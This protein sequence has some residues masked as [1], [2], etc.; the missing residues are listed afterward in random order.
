M[1]EKS[2]ATSWS[3]VR[4]DTK[5]CFGWCLGEEEDSLGRV[6]SSC[7]DSKSSR[8][9]P[10]KRRPVREKSQEPRDDFVLEAVLLLLLGEIVMVQVLSVWIDCL[11]VEENKPLTSTRDSHGNKYE[12]DCSSPMNECKGQNS[13][14]S[15]SPKIGNRENRLW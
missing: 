1:V 15:C 14:D 2:S 4:L 12:V 9:L 7:M 10:D 3:A 11:K 8:L 13:G 6:S 5:G